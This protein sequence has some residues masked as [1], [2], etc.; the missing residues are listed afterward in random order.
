V[1]YYNV[2]PGEVMYIE[3][4]GTWVY[5]SPSSVYLLQQ[6]GTCRIRFNP[7]SSIA[8]GDPFTVRVRFGF[9]GVSFTHTFRWR[10]LVSYLPLVGDGS[11]AQASAVF[12][13]GCMAH[14]KGVVYNDANGNGRRDVGEEAIPGAL[15][16]LYNLGRRRGRVTSGAD[17]S[18]VFSNLDVG[19]Y[20]LVAYPVE[21]MRPV[22]ANIYIPV[23][24]ARVYQQDIAYRR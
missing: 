18:Y 24:G 5:F 4:P 19:T 9:S 13:D 6:Q 11:V 10:S 17:G 12:L 3:A 14:I 8:P 23:M 21:G 7:P 1:S 20:T 15:V 2:S 16:E 22:R